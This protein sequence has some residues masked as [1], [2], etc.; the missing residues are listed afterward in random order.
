[1]LLAVTL[2]PLKGHDPHGGAGKKLIEIPIEGTIDLGLAAFVERSVA[3]ATTNDVIVLKI[4]TFGGRV[5][6]AVRIRDVL[7]EANAPTVAFIDHRAI[8]AGALI[9]LACDTILV[10][11]GASIGAA[12]PVESGPQGQMQPTAE[13]VIS[14]M[15]AEMRATAEAKGRRTDIAEAMVD[16][17]IEIAGLNPKGKLL[18]LTGEQA[19]KLLRYPARLSKWNQYLQPVLPNDSGTNNI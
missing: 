4:K 3:Q 11:P 6:A 2:P 5:D 10:S 17:D 12:T 9:T 1:M 18:T 14:Y 15:R 19:I 7:L 16:P 8:S 13:K